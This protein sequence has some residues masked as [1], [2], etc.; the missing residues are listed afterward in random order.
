[1]RKPGIRKSL[2]FLFLVALA[3]GSSSLAGASSGMWNLASPGAN[4]YYGYGGGGY[5]YS[6]GTGQ[7]PQQYMNPWQDPAFVYAMSLNW[8]GARP[9]GLSYMPAV[10]VDA[11]RNSLAAPSGGR[12]Y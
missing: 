10:G 9:L 4:G 2:S 12:A 11:I 5:S 8:S 6:Y 1:M 3:M 7:M